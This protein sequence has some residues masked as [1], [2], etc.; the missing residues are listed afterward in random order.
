MFIY[1]LE[2]PN[3]QKH[4]LAHRLYAG[5]LNFH[6]GKYWFLKQ[7]IPKKHNQAKI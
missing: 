5:N 3:Q 2:S 1:L 7:R 4:L 6:S